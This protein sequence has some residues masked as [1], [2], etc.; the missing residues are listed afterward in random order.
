VVDDEVV[1]VSGGS[2]K[3][4]NGVIGVLVACLLGG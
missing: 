4:G 3:E 2:G 1:G